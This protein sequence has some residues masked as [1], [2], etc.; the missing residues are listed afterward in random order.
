MLPISFS[1]LTL[2]SMF[3]LYANHTYLFSWLISFHTNSKAGKIPAGLILLGSSVATDLGLFGSISDLVKIK[4][5]VA[6]VNFGFAQITKV[7]AAIKHIIRYA[8]DQG[9]DLDNGGDDEELCD[10]QQQV[11]R[12]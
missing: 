7:K 9:S 3:S 8:T 2:R 6:A 4:Q 5:R 1:Q 10:E 11:S 12:C